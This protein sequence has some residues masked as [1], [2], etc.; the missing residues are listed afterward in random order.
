M[1]VKIIQKTVLTFCLLALVGF[2]APMLVH[3]AEDRQ[4]TDSDFHID[5]EGCLTSYTGSEEHVVIPEGVKRIG[6]N[7]DNSIFEDTETEIKSV[8]IPDSVIEIGERAFYTC[9][10]L[11]E[12]TMGNGVKKI[13]QE[14]FAG[15]FKM[16]TIHLSDSLQEI[17]LRAFNFCESLEALELPSSLRN[18]EMEAFGNCISLKSLNIPDGVQ[19]IPPGTFDRCSS[20]EELYI[21]SSVTKIGAGSK[22]MPQYVGERTGLEDCDNLTIYGAAG[23]AAE[24][25]AQEKDI[26]FVEDESMQSTVIPDSEEEELETQEEVE[27]EEEAI[28]EETDK[29]EEEKKESTQKTQSKTSV[30]RVQIVGLTVGAVGLVMILIAVVIQIIRNSRRK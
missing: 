13:G 17:G 8:V 14:A 16:K 1:R 9:L 29:D 7:P 19:A 25:Y 26:T 30:D 12:V 21:P 3:G 6:G 24:K 5:K 10:Q 22:L 27:E 15:C 20:M 4:S 23:S 11:E 28:E 18:I 2:S